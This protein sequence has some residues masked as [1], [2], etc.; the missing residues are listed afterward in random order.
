[1]SKDQKTTTTPAANAK[2]EPTNKIAAIF[3]EPI[4]SLPANPKTYPNA[5]GSSVKTVA[6]VKLPIKGTGLVVNAKINYAMNRTDRDANG[7]YQYNETYLQLPTAGMARQAV[8]EA[9]T[10]TAVRELEEWKF[11]VCEKY[12]AWHAKIAESVEVGGE[13]STNPLPRL[14][15]RIAAPAAP[16]PAAPAR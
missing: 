2:A 13:A 8:F 7:P 5:D 9:N 10:T 1:M 16:A 4:F 6:T 15:K 14:I 12:E 3:G 11:A